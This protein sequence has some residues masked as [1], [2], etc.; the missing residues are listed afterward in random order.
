MIMCMKLRAARQGE[1]SRLVLGPVASRGAPAG[2]AAVPSA[3]PRHPACCL[4]GTRPATASFLPPRGPQ[5]QTARVPRLPA[6]AALEQGYSSAFWHRLQR[7]RSGARCSDRM[8]TYQAGPVLVECVDVQCVDVI[9]RERAHGCAGRARG[10]RALAAT[11]RAL[12][13]GLPVGRVSSAKGPPLPARISGRLLSLERRSTEAARGP[14][15]EARNWTVGQ[16]YLPSSSLCIH[17][18]DPTMHNCQVTTRPLPA[19][20]TADEVANLPKGACSGFWPLRWRFQVARK[21]S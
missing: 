16:Q 14:S 18:P 17:Q 19:A 5:V 10:L 4:T 2:H 1:G 6:P 13:A 15:Q 7:Q 3:H 21:W 9:P 20:P 12:A 11:E 8:Q